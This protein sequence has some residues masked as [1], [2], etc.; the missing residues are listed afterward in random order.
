MCVYG[1]R[2]IHPRASHSKAVAKV[3][4]KCTKQS[5]LV[6]TFLADT[7]CEL[8]LKFLL[9]GQQIVIGGGGKDAKK[10][11]IITSGPL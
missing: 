5:E 7:W 6:C 3:Y 1:I 10:P 4:H 8:R 2:G 9:D 11:V